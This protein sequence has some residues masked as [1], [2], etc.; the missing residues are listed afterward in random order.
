MPTDLEE[1]ELGITAH[2]Y[3]ASPISDNIREME[4]GTLVI[5]SCPIARTGWMTYAVRDLPQEAARRLGVDVSNPSANIDLYRAP[6]DVFAPEFL[7]SLNGRPITENHPPDFVT[8]DTFSK[9]ALGH[10]QNVRKGDEP[11][12]NGDWPI[13]ADLIISGEPLVSKV[14]NKQ[15]RELSLGYDYAIKRA[16]DQI[17]QVGMM[18]NH[19]AVVPQGRA[20]DEV[21]I[22]DAAPAN[23]VSSTRAAPSE[24]EASPPG[25]GARLAAQ[26][27]NASPTKKEKPKVKNNWKHIF[28]LGLRAKAADADTDPEELAELALDIGKHGRDSEVDEEEEL[29]ED[30]RVKDR[31]AKDRKKAKDLEEDPTD[32]DHEPAM[33]RKRRAMHDALDK[34]IDGEHP[35]DDKRVKDEDLNELGDMLKEFFG[36]EAKEPEHQVAD[37]FEEEPEAVDADPA[38]L[39]EL[40]GAGEEPDAEDAVE[41]DPGEEILESG[42][43]ALVEDG[44][45]EGECAHCGEVTDAANC[46]KCGCTD[47]KPVKDKARAADAAVGVRAT[48]KYLRPFIARSNDSALKAAFN[49]TLGMTSRTSRA[50]TG[51]YGAF[52]NSARARDSKRI[53]TASPVAAAAEANT[54]LQSVYDQLHEKGGK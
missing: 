8:P 25:P 48:L 10:I 5:E 19:L 31:K 39:E 42:E 22:N 47:R 14:L 44:V 50:S 26:T 2:G 9:Y 23:Q 54:K 6:Q 1:Q 45:E 37:N 34:L 46:P 49:T 24:P 28:G 20:G 53:G 30:R 15:L 27:V 16:G 36:Q 32:Y 43:E 33:D 35:A 17:R 41:P 18:G 38:E 4:D 13:V 21:R 7:A 51:S 3:L 52:A 12:D 29:A 11:L 40:L